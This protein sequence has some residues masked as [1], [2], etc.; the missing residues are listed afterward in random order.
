MSR[1]KIA[2]TSACFNFAYAIGNVL[3]GVLS[4]SAWFVTVGVYYLI[5]G[6]VRAAALFNM[7]KNSSPTLLRFFGTSLII[8]SLPLLVMVFLSAVKERRSRYH[9]ILMITIALYTFTRI[10]IAIINLYKSGGDGSDAMM[11][12]VNLGFLLIKKYR[13]LKA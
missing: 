10:T 7:K 2:P 11:V 13:D 1:L 6:I 8:V 4:P 5:I 3:L 9:E 12:L